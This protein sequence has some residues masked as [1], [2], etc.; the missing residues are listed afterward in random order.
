MSLLIIVTSRC[1]QTAEHGDVCAVMS[2]PIASTPHCPGTGHALRGM[3]SALH[4]LSAPVPVVIANPFLQQQS[5]PGAAYTQP[6]VCSPS[7][8][9]CW[10]MECIC[11]RSS[12]AL[13][14]AWCFLERWAQRTEMSINWRRCFGSCC[15]VAPLCW[16]GLTQL[17]N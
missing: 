17:Q 10:I 5:F 7:K 11:M 12:P 16:V 4:S 13:L 8:V 9:T 15:W 3:P 6:A 14:V 1:S 2:V